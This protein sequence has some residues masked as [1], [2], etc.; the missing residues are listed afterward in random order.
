MDDTIYYIQILHKASLLDKT[1]Y[2]LF[3]YEES[4]NDALELIQSL[5]ELTSE[6]RADIHHDFKTAT[7]KLIH[8]KNI[9][10][11]ISHGAM[12]YAE[13]KDDFKEIVLQS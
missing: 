11:V 1:E 8:L 10:D 6:E 2:L 7:G 5:L 4:R 3:N 9:I 12:I 13:V